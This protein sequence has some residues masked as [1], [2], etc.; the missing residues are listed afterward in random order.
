LEES[1]QLPLAKEKYL[2]ATAIDPRDPALWGNLGL[3]SMHMRRPHEASL[4]FQKARD[5]TPP[6]STLH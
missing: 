5:L 3:L 2:A 6:D 1:E 4:Y